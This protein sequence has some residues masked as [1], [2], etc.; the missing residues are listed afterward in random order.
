MPGYSIWELLGPFK[1]SAV[2]DFRRIN[3]EVKEIVVSLD[4][5]IKNHQRQIKALV[6]AKKVLAH[7]N[8]TGPGAR[9]LS[10]EARKRIGKAQRARWA[11]IHGI[12]K[13]A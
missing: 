10:A 9:V 1:G 3:L 11:K 5:E 8:R 7:L 6:K 12:R 2:N 13:A 4:K